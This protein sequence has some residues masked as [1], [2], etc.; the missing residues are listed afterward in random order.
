M[1][2]L[3]VSTPPERRGSQAQPSP[4]RHAT[5]ELG[6]DQEALLVAVRGEVVTSPRRTSAQ[7]VYFDLD[8]GSGPLRVYVSPRTGIATSSIALGSTLE[9]TGVLGQETSGQ[10]PLR[11]YRLWPRTDADVKVV[12]ASVQGPSASPGTSESGSGGPGGAAPI[13]APAAGGAAPPRA[14]DLPVPRLAAGRLPSMMPTPTPRAGAVGAVASRAANGLL[15]VAPWLAVA[16]AV[17]AGL[18]AVTA[19]RPGLI[20]RLRGAVARPSSAAADAEATAPEEPR[21]IAPGRPSPLEQTVARLVPLVVID[22]QASEQAVRSTAA[23][24]GTRRIL[25]PT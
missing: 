6:E 23:R 16:A 25:P 17:L 19:A 8:D 13:G 22:D 21:E 7:N 3:L 20:Q 14:I 12:A 9:L 15:D 2:T 5:G 18:A 4:S 10:Q 11:G 24:S 1:E